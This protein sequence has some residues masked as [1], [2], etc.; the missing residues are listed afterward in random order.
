[1][2]LIGTSIGAASTMGKAGKAYEIGIALFFATMAY[3]VGLFIF[4]LIAP[5]IRRIKIWNIPDALFLRYGGGIRFVF[6][7]T[8]VL[9]VTAVFGTQLIAVGLAVTS[10]MGELGITYT[11]AIIGAGIIMVLYTMLGGLLAVAYTDLLQTILMI[12]AIGIILPLFIISDIGIS[13]TIEYLTPPP[14]NFWGGLTPVYIISI[15]LIDLPFSLI[16]P[17]L[18][19]RAAAAKDS[20]VIRRAMFLTSGV[21]VFWSFIV[22][23]LGVM[24]SHILPGL[25]ESSGGVDAAI[26]KLIVQYMPL[27]L[28][29]LCLA[30]MMAIMMSTADTVLLIAGTSVSRD[31]FHALRPNTD[32]RTLLRVA[33]LFIL[34]VG[35]LGVI[36]AL[37]MK[38]IFDLILLAFAIFVSGAFVPT[39]AALF[40]KKATK[41]GAIASSATASLSVVS[42]YGLKMSNLL[43]SWTE[44]IIISILVS[45]ILMV[46][47]SKATYNSETATPRLIDI[48]DFKGNG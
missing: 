29:G 44:P 38:G 43:P 17:S 1:G 3:A 24:A 14:G 39:M 13:S 7:I 40:W 4:G 48:D 36:F 10:I 32:D 16:D 34:F 33:R 31:I 20:K 25:T 11:Q 8:M 26:P 2:T 12:A 18:W 21:Y 6:A 9:S 19:Q 28:K 5:S 15:V 30:A 45:F 37:N 23:F 35:V 22:V 42:L 41:A 47:V 46:V 27:G